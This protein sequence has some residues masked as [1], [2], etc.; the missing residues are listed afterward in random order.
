MGRQENESV[1]RKLH[2]DFTSGDVDAALSNFSDDAVWHAAGNAPVSGD[3]RGKDAIGKMF[4]TVMELSG[5]TFNPELH[6]IAASDDHVVFIGT[7][8]GQ[9]AGKTLDQNFTAVFH[10]KDGKIAEVW[11]SGYDQKAMDDFWS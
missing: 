7:Q 9:R 1:L 5:G 4:G 8:K 10:V 6:D 3:F 11:E 2:K